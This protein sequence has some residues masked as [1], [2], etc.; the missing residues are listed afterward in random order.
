MEAEQQAEYADLQSTLHIHLHGL[1][2]DAQ[3]QPDLASRAGELAAELKAAA[4]RA[5]L[6]VEELTA[7]IDLNVRAKPEVFGLS[8]ITETTIASVV[9]TRPQTKEAKQAQIAAERE[10]DLAATLANAYEHRRSMLKIEVDLWMSN[11]WGDVEVK[12]RDMRRTQ[13]D[14]RAKA[15][16]EKQEAVEAKRAERKRR[17]RAE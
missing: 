10:A 12:E 11:Y 7:Q 2:E 3:D 15:A 14:A 5:K 16:D 6:A 1:H 4:K 17:R 8:K 13:A 9:A